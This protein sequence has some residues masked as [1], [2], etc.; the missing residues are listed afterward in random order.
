MIWRNKLRTELV[1]CGKFVR[2]YDPASGE[3]LWMM[4]MLGGRASASPVGNSDALF[5]G[6]E[7]GRE[8]GR[9]SC[10]ERV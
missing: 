2:S 5:L 1:T 9:A 7:Q 3:L 8:I 4:D 10:R 6:N